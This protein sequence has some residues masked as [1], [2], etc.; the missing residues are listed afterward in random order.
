MILQQKSKRSLE[1]LKNVF[2]CIRS[3]MLIILAICFELAQI[4]KY[5]G[6]TLL[7]NPSVWNFVTGPIWIIFWYLIGYK[8]MCFFMSFQS[9]SSYFYIIYSF[10]WIF[11]LLRY[12]L[13]TKRFLKNKH[14]T[15]YN[16]SLCVEFKSCQ[17]VSFVVAKWRQMRYQITIDAIIRSK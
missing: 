12:D 16:E 1:S 4:S 5:M 11:I 10:L 9:M 17:T 3:M 15:R 13:C 8:N 6:F 7:W 14:N 2:R